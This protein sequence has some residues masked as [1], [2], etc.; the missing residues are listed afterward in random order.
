[1]LKNELEYSRRDLRLVH[2]ATHG[3]EEFFNRGLHASTVTMTWDG[4]STNSLTV[5][6]PFYWL[7]ALASD[8]CLLAPKSGA[9]LAT[10]FG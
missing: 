5:S 8:M 9:S 10:G 4:R 2:A 3:D 1:M 7:D 6:P